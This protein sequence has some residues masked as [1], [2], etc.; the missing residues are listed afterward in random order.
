MTYKEIESI[1]K[2]Y[3]IVG[4][5]INDDGSI[6][7]DGDVNLV[8]F[9]L[10]ELPVKFNKVNGNFYCHNNQLTT[11]KGCP[12]EVSKDLW[13]DSNELTSLEGCPIYVGGDFDCNDNNLTSLIGSPIE[14]GGSFSCIYNQLSS[15][16]DLPTVL[17]YIDFVNNPLHPF[18]SDVHNML[19]NDIKIFIKYMDHYEVF[20]PVFNAVNGLD[21]IDEIKDGLR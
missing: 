6:D 14:V 4:Y 19:G 13:I 21:L 15:L 3:G 12:S 8:N 7:V 18:Y 2:K 10:N 5:S 20:E 17:G 9:K 16:V 1:C 11:L